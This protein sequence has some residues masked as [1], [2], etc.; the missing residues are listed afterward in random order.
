MSISRPI[1][2]D[3]AIS[4]SDLET[5][6]SRSWVWSKGKVIQP[7]QHPINSL[8]L[9]FT[10]IRP[11]IPEIQ[12]FQN[13]TLKHPRPRSWVRSHYINMRFSQWKTALHV[14][15]LSSLVQRLSE[16]S[17]ENG[18]RW[19]EYYEKS[20]SSYMLFNTDFLTWT[21]AK[22]ENCC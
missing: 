19:L 5:P 7:A 16:T 8:P 1:H 10:S 9:H 18:S 4:N 3:K 12:L 20:I 21:E 17:I 2:C 13:L 6:R 14:Q 11:T 15:P 22:F